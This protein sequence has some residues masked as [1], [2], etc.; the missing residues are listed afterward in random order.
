MRE[1]VRWERQEAAVRESR[2]VDIKENEKLAFLGTFRPM[3]SQDDVE[4]YLTRLEKHWHNCGVDIATW[5]DWLTSKLNGVWRDRLEA[6]T[7]PMDMGYN[8]IKVKLLAAGGL[9][10][11][12]AGVEIFRS[13]S[14]RMTNPSAVDIHSHLL[15]ERLE[16]VYH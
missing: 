8:D 2:A 11:R 5:P 6:L 7:I 14:D 3:G 10:P 4:A 9:S 1:R 15:R 13:A 16:G 12:E